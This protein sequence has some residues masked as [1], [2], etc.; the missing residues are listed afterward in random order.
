[1]TWGPSEKQR[2]Q[3]FIFG[4]EFATVPTHVTTCKPNIAGKFTAILTDLRD[5]N[6]TFAVCCLQ[7]NTVNS[8]DSQHGR[9]KQTETKL[10][11]TS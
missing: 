6:T 5:K 2:S 3:R 7:L 4:I 9:D 10:R 8:P 11:T 1:M